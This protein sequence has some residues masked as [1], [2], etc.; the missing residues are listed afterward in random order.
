MGPEL[1]YVLNFLVGRRFLPQ[2][3]KGFLINDKRRF[4]RKSFGIHHINSVTARLC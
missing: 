2:T 1:L 3:G 4:R